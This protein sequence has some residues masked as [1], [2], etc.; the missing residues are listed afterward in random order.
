RTVVAIPHALLFRDQGGLAQSDVGGAAVEVFDVEVVRVFGLDGVGVVVRRVGAPGDGA[1]VKGDVVSV[2]DREA[3]RVMRL[4]GGQRGGGAV[5]EEAAF[6]LR[7]AVER[8]LHAV[9]ADVVDRG[10]RIGRGAIAG[11]SDG[12]LGVA[13]DVLH[14]DAV[15]RAELCGRRARDG[16]EGDGLP[17]APPGVGV[18]ARG[19]GDVLVSDVMDGAFVAELDAEAA[20]AGLDLAALEEDVVDVG[21]GFRPDLEA[22]VLRF[23][24]AVRDV[25]VGG[26][27]VVLR[28][29]RAFDDHAIVAAD[30][31]AVLDFDVTRV[32]GIDAVAVGHVEQVTD[33]YV[34]YEDAVAAEQVQAPV[35]GF[36]KGDVA[37]LEVA[38]AGEDEHL[39]A[40]GLGQPTLVGLVV[41]GHELAGAALQRAGAGD[42]QTLRV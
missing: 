16:G 34:V 21:S 8:D 22:G 5:V 14:G 2:F 10:R 24:D 29:A 36:G 40:E 38:A 26:G 3:G 11:N 37:D 18:E 31:I 27:A 30:Q 7:S 32:V 35:G 4:D 9:E 42:A 15:Q 1:V 13:G 25:D 28:L 41:A 20:R 39:G 33:F 23:D 12:I 17:A 6:V 19:E